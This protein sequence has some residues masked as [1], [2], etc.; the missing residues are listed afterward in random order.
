LRQ[1]PERRAP[2]HRRVGLDR[3]RLRLGHTHYVLK[4]RDLTILP[5]EGTT[6]FPT[7]VAMH[8]MA[9]RLEVFARW[10]RGLMDE[11]WA[12]IF[13]DGPYPLER[14]MGTLRM[15]GH[16]WYLY[17]GNT[18]GFRHSVRRSEERLLGVLEERT[19]THRLD[20]ARTILLGFSQ[21]GYFAGSLGLR[22]AERFAGIAV[23][24]GR[25]RPGI[26]CRSVD[27]IPRIPILFIH[28]KGDDMVPLEAAR[29]SAD[30]MRALG[31]PVTWAEVEGTHRWNGA[32]S[33]AFRAWARQRLAP[34]PESR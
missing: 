34:T 18:P 22:Y 8:G 11:P 23:A 19:R 5:E 20:P 31:F 13:P 21:G 24:A 2:L 27:E 7:I 1:R 14:R 4:K 32:M 15:I 29:E 16:A 6:P 28:G 17:D 12:W 30:E 9:M 25:I 26:A 3:E 10:L 33:E